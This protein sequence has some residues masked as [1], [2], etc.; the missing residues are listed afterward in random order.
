MATSNETDKEKGKAMEKSAPG[1][2]LS[3]F[4]EMDRMFE[5]FFPRGWMQPMRWGLPAWSTMPEPF[6]G[7]MPKVDVVDR[8][9][10]ILVRAELPGVDKKDVDISTTENSVTIKG[11]TRKEEKEEKG[12]Y[13]R[14]EISSGAFTRTLAL[15]GNVDSSNAKAEFKDGVL[16][17]TLPKVEKSKRQKIEIS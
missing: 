5:G 14:C 9:N 11:S 13:Y 6:E 16:E 15:P 4:E 2:A 8:D 12:D 3:P 10:E 17:L 1:R 7:R